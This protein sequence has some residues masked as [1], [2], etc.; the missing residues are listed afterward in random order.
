MKKTFKFGIVALLILTVVSLNLFSAIERN[1]NNELKL[2]D[3]KS[4]NAAT[5]EDAI[6]KW[7]KYWPAV[8]GCC[9]HDTRD[10]TNQNFCDDTDCN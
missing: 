8:E 4:A 2:E 1:S 3:I 9:E 10:C 7:C 6:N 5:H